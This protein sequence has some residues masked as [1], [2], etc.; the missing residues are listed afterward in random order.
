MI[1][2]AAPLETDHLPEPAFEQLAEAM[3]KPEPVAL[4]ALH[5]V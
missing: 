3:H 2:I 4:L 1:A 5:S